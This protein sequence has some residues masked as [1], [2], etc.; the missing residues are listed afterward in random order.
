MAKK[1][2]EKEQIQKEL[3]DTEEEAK[4]IAS[5]IDKSKY[6]LDKTE[7]FIKLLL[8]NSNINW[9]EVRGILEEAKDSLREIFLD[10]GDE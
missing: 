7:S 3:T 1:L 9:Y 8:I 4:R 6:S 10:D 5:W 2:T